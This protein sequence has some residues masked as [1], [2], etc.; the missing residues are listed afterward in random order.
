MTVLDIGCGSK[1]RGD[2][3]VDLYPTGFYDRVLSVHDIPNFVKAHA[4]FLPF[5]DKAFETVFA[6]HILE[7]L[8]QPFTALEEWERV[9]SERVIVAV[10]CKTDL[11][12]FAHEF[13]DHIYSWTPSTLQN[14][15]MRVFPRVKILMNKARPIKWLIHGQLASIVN[16]LIKILLAQMQWFQSPELVA[17]GYSD[18]RRDMD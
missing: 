3:N 16:F 10:P 12:Y 13:P 15:M 4:L 17:V 6:S 18:E 7:H 2:V 5:P 8:E 1:P 9:A 14:L 11:K